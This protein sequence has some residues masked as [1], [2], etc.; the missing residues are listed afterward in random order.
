MRQKHGDEMDSLAAYERKRSQAQTTHGRLLALKQV[1]LSSLSPPLFPFRLRKNCRLTFPASPS[2]RHIDLLESRK[3][4][5]RDLSEKHNIPG[6]DHELSD[7]EMAEFEEKME[8][9]IVA[10]QRK[11]DKIKVRLSLSLSLPSFTDGVAVC[12]TKLASL[13]AST[14][15]RFRRSRVRGR[16]MRG[17]R[18]ASLSR[19]CVSLP[20]PLPSPPPESP[21]LTHPRLKSSAN[22][23]IATISRQL[24]STTTTV[25]D[26]TYATS[27]LTDE[28]TRLAKTKE[29]L[30]AA[31]YPDALRARA[32]EAKDLEERRESLHTELAGLNAQANTRAKL[33]LRKTE[34]K[35]KD[36]AVA[37]LIEKS[38]ASF[39]RFAKS[40]PVR[41]TMEAEVTALI[42]CVLEF[43][44][45]PSSP[46][47]AGTPD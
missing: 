44:V 15:T 33:Q 36:E 37:S 26:I 24:D 27:V 18:R 23:R 9:A 28:Q 10:Q 20:P 16:R 29:D 34:K 8:E 39:R 41:G 30:A 31:A 43:L 7:R 25:A 4:L 19:S 22:N 3:A 12:R 13:K 14:K 6:Y 11:V 32:R 47:P 17:R 40:E 42:T 1:R 46:F 2:Q 38:A 5:I 45:L 21:P 35:R